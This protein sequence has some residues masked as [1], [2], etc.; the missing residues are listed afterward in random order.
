M[1]KQTAVSSKWIKTKMLE[2]SSSLAAHIPTTLRLTQNTLNRMLTRYGMVYVKPVS[3]S[4][5]IGVMRVE[6]S[7]GKWKVQ[8][9]LKISSFSTFQKMFR[10]L[11]SQIRGTPYLVQRGIHVLRH[12]GRPLDFRVMIQ[13]ARLQGWLVTGTAA[14]VAHP[15]KAV[16][17][18]SQ[19]GSIFGAKSLLRRIAGRKQA[20]KALKTFNRLAYS[21]AR[22][23]TLAYPR[24]REL[25]LDI[26]VDTK[27]RAWILEVNTKPDPCPFTKLN[28]SS[29]IRNIVKIARGYGRTYCLECNKAKRG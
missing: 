26:A 28:D 3:G 23:F 11:R 2:G 9:G 19:G 17:N 7:K 22:R 24:M 8:S 20:A 5:G 4:L 16:T 10:W 15:R 25:G 21:T 27:D 18:G 1:N 13:K 14:R 6:R 29:M 12:R